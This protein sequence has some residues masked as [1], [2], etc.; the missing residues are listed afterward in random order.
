MVHVPDLG[1]LRGCRKN[2]VHFFF[3]YITIVKNLHLSIDNLDNLTAKA[4]NNTEAANFGHHDEL[5]SVA[6]RDAGLRDPLRAAQ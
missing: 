1:T 6:R 3:L 5:E 2:H 4:D